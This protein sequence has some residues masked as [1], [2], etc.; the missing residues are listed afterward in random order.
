VDDIKIRRLGGAGRIIRLGDERIPIKVLSEKFHNTR[1]VGKTRTRWGD[2]RMDTRH[3][4]R[5]YEYGREE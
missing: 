2:V 1:P 3:R 4:Y 5:E